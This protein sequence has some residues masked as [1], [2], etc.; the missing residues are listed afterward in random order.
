MQQLPVIQPG[1]PDAAS[2]APP[3]FDKIG[4]V[5]LGLIGGSI[6]LAARQLWPKALVIG[7]DNKD[8]L[9]TAMRLHAIDVAADDLIVLA[10]ADVV[11]L[12]A[13]VRVNIALLADLDENVRQPAVVTD[14]GSTKRD[15][16]AAASSLP[17]RLTF[18]GGHPLAGAAHGGLE[19]ARAD[20]FSGRPWLLTPPVVDGGPD[21]T[22]PPS[23]ATGERRVQP[24]DPGGAALAKLTGFVQALGAVPRVVGAQAHDRLLA[25]LSHLPQ[26]TASAL[27]QVIGESVG[28]DGLALAG[29]GLADTTRLASSPADIWTDI[30]ATNADEIGHA[31]GALIALLQDLRRDLSDGDKLADV[32]AA[33]ARWRGSLKK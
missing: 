15:I 27:M 13:P 30:A 10:E 4:I 7:V 12:A 17:A 1:R 14:T 28:Q 11:I 16:M 20:L 3:I 18:I 22:R 33:A 24:G 5:G 32:F 25:F 26:L 31:L 9:E 19:H 21:R 23:A 2:G 8:V 29:R 6:A